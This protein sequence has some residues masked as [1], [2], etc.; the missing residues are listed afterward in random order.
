M[1]VEFPAKKTLALLAVLALR[2]G[3]PFEREWLAALLW[4]DVTEAQA[5]TSLRQALGHLRKA[6]APELVSGGADRV[7]VEP[8][9]VR[10]D[11]AEVAEVLLRAPKER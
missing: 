9:L 10:V 3:V 2:P 11:T 4:P 8:A 7:H 6:I 1:R 5:R